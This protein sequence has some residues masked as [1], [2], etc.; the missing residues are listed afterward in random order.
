MMPDITEDSSCSNKIEP[1]NTNFSVPSRRQQN[2]ANSLTTVKTENVFKQ[3]QSLPLLAPKPEKNE[4]AKE[5]QIKIRKLI[6]KRI[7]LSPSEPNKNSKSKSKS[8][9]EKEIDTIFISKMRKSS[10]SETKKVLVPD[11][12]EPGS[13]SSV[14]PIVNEDICSSCGGLGN[15]ICCD[16]CPRSFHFT[17]A[18]PPLD[19]ENLPENDWFCCECRDDMDI[20]VEADDYRNGKS[21][22]ASGADTRTNTSTNTNS[23]RST[24]NIACVTGTTSIWDVMLKDATR[25]NPKNFVMPRRFR[26]Q[27]K[28]E[29]LLRIKSHQLFQKSTDSPLQPPPLPVPAPSCQEPKGD[30]VV[31]DTVRLDHCGI[32]APN[33]SGIKASSGYCHCC[34][35]FGVT[36]S[37]LFS[38]SR[39]DFVDT[40]IPA[41]VRFQ[42]P[43]LSCALCPLYWHLDCLDPPMAVFPGSVD[44][45]PCPIHFT[46]EKCLALELAESLVQSTLLL[47]ESAILQ[48]FRHK[49]ARMGEEQRMRQSFGEE[50]AFEFFYGVADTISVPE[51]VKS[52]YE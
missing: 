33:I 44:S 40:G 10:K 19:P 12:K 22:S 47:P 2:F 15:F 13:I 21:A 50:D 37:V 3:K 49:R 41:D 26:Y 7:I 45:W 51:A 4:P 43:M 17:C 39:D 25:M 14:K 5:P 42:R 46:E 31:N 29:D 1:D 8:E 11:S 9:T 36:K 16:A 38:E 32:K 48:Q 35:R 23:A 30:I 20:G 6:K 52:V 34:G 27:P 28:E 24:R 18:E